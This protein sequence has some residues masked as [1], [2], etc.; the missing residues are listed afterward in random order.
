MKILMGVDDSKSCEDTIHAV[1]AQF[2]AAGTEVLVLHVLQPMGPAAPQMDWYFAPELEAEKEAAD[3]LVERVATELRA[4]GF[5]TATKIDIG[6]IR[7][8]ILNRAA[9]WGADLIL[10]GPH[11]Q[12][13][14]QRFLL[15]GVSEFV[16]RHAKCSVEVVRA[17]QPATA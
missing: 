13:G 15:G 12:G 17:A 14:F 5:K 16:M 4:A 7:Q 10:L 1:I 2:P 8:G 3:S 6:D 11:G 9:D